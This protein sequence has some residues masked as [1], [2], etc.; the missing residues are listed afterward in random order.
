MGALMEERML[1]RVRAA[2]VPLQV[3]AKGA[4]L[5]VCRDAVMVSIALPVLLQHCLALLVRVA[6]AVV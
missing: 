5:P 3:K 6:C 4:S 1:H 2:M